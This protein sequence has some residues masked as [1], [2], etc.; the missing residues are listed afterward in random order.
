MT[1]E[2]AMK[3][4]LGAL[5]AAFV[6]AFAPVAAAHDYTKGAL[7]IDHP[8]VSPINPP[9]TVTAGYFTIRNK[10]GRDRLISA[11]SPMAKS[12]E[13]HTHRKGQ[14]GMMRMEMVKAG[15]VV[16]AKGEV[17]FKPGGLHLM[18]FG[19]SAAIKEG[20]AIPVT[21]VFEK[22]GAIEVMAMGEQPS[23]SGAGHKH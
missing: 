1:G 9:R 23:L 11:S 14:G 18:L 13:I 16:P 10:G 5:V 8:I 22:A 20:D 17:A 3:T 6:L 19:V 2:I 7:T 12:V 15:V 4:F 21:L